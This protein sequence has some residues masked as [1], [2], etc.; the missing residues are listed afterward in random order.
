MQPVSTKKLRFFPVTLSGTNRLPMYVTA[1]VVTCWS[2]GRPAG[3][4]PAGSVSRFTGGLQP[5]EST[6]RLIC[7]HLL[8]GTVSAP[9]A[10]GAYTGGFSVLLTGCLCTISTPF[11]SWC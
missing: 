1:W 10:A 3:V 8:D 9:G 11:C 6:Q 2:L 4:Q 5:V 7:S